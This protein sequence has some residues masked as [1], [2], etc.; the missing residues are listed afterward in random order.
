MRAA[1]SLVCAFLTG[2]ANVHLP[3][4][5]NDALAVH[6]I[7]PGQG[8]SCEYL[9]NV[10]YVSKLSGVGKSYE[11]VHQAGE[12]GL[13]DAVAAAGGNAFAFIQTDADPFWGKIDY[14]AQAFKCAKDQYPMRSTQT[15]R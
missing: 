8:L 2:C 15:S 11:L 13:R 12:N 14:S 9:R 6:E 1:I 7:T 5:S 10:E 4:I 3:P